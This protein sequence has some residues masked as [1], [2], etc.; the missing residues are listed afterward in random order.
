MSIT[1]AEKIESSPQAQETAAA[2]RRPDNAWIWQVTALSVVLGGMLALAVRT[3]E[4]SRQST[5]PGGNRLGLLAALIDREK[6]ESEVLQQEI[7]ELRRRQDAYLAQA[8]TGDAELNR[9]RTE[10]DT[11]KQLAGLSQVEGIGLK[12]TVRDSPD[13]PPENVPFEE[14]LVHDQDLNNII[15]SLKAAGAQHLAISGADSARLQRVVVS[16]TARCVGP[17]AVVNGT[18]LSAPYH[19]FA[20]GDPKAMRAALDDPAGWVRSRELDTKKMIEIEERERVVL[21]EYS[22]KLQGRHARPVT[23]AGEG[24]K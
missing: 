3:T 15:S 19:I 17:T 20:I 5:A 16:T 4:A 14:Y 21:P 12:I 2:P 1:A 11:V 13:T 10:F 18:Y 8:Q 6:Q 7:T 9:L 24:K 22:G 23:P